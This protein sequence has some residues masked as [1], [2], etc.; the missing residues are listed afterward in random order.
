MYKV[1]RAFKT[2]NMSTVK[3]LASSSADQHVSGLII[4]VKSN[5]IGRVSVRYYTENTDK[6]LIK[7]N[8]WCWS[9][10]SQ[11]AGKSIK[12]VDFSN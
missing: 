5:T 3:G 10:C 8:F 7:P 12:S 1:N 6:P 11:K 4:K 9:L 2:L